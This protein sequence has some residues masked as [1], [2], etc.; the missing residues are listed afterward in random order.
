MEIWSKETRLAEESMWSLPSKTYWGFIPRIALQQE[1][2]YFLA[3][4]A[5][6]CP[7]NLFCLLQRA[8]EVVSRIFITTIWW[9]HAQYIIAWHQFFAIII[10]FMYNSNLSENHRSRTPIFKR[11]FDRVVKV[12]HSKCIGKLPRRFK[13]CSSRSLLFSRI[14]F[15]L[16]LLRWTLLPPVENFAPEDVIDTV[17]HHRRD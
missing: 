7:S 16:S 15:F 1:C 5:N 17:K 2:T 14:L 11:L 8:A 9:L 3:T 12:I 4:R 6:F 13:S 10:W